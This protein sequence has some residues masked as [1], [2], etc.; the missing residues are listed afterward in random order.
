MIPEATIEPPRRQP[1]WLSDLPNGWRIERA[2]VFFR[3]VDERSEKGEEELLSV[4]H[5]TGVTKRSEKNI[6]MFQAESRYFYLD[7]LTPMV[8]GINK[9]LALGVHFSCD[10][11]G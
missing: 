7:G 5:L 11:L 4:S 6:T 10:T 3:K 9:K 1:A 2:K 8:T